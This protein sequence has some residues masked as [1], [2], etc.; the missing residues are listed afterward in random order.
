[1]QKRLYVGAFAV[2]LTALVSPLALDRAVPAAPADAAIESQGRLK[3]LPVGLARKFA[4]MATFSPGAAE[5]VRGT[6]RRPGRAGLDRALDAGPRHSVRGLRRCAE[7]LARAEGTARGRRRRLDSPGTGERA[8]GREP[9]PGPVRLQRRHRELQRPH[10]RRRDRSGLR[11]GRLPP[12]A[13]QRQRRRLDDQRRAG[14]GAGVGVPVSHTSSTTTSPRWRSTRTT[15]GSNTLWAGTG[16]PNACGSG[17]TAGVG[18]YKTHERR[19]I[20]DRA[21]S[22][23]RSSPAAPWARSPCKPGNS[24]VDLRGLRPRRAAACRTPAAA[25]WTRSFPA[26][27]TSACIAR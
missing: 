21:R 22:A 8:V 3:K 27:R 18:L 7:R 20:L 17:C 1:M 19:D 26:R 10:H 5:S 4:A 13:R 9:V 12:V 2:A 11:A 6:R 15:S 16:E 14:A 25:A 23:P 24:S